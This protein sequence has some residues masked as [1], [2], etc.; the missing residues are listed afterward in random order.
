MVAAS[1][2]DSRVLIPRAFPEPAGGFVD[3][4]GDAVADRGLERD[5]TRALAARVV[6]AGLQER[7][8]DALAPRSDRHKEIAQEP[9]ALEFE[10][11]KLRI[12]LGETQCGL[13]V[14]GDEDDRLVAFEAIA[15][16]GPRG[17][18]L[19]RAAI[20]GAIRIEERREDVEVGDGRTRD[21]GR[22]GVQLVMP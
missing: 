9:V 18:A 2:Q 3:P 5:R 13:A 14:A 11:G 22:L 16:E 10:R 21:D 8:A 6:F 19:E 12:E 17:L 4:L 20:E 15:E 7:S 1:A